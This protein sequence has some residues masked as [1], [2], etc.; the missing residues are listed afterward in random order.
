M[1]YNGVYFS[2]FVGLQCTD[3]NSNVNRLHHR[4]FMLYVLKTSC[5]KEI[6]LR[7]KP[8]VYKGFNYDAAL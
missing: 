2:K 6:I 3:C 8:M 5:L 7:K 1:I 4:F